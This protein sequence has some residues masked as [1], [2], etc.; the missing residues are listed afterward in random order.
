MNNINFGNVARGVMSGIDSLKE[1]AIDKMRGKEISDGQKIKE[2]SAQIKTV[3]QEIKELQKQ[4]KTGYIVEDELKTKNAELGK[5][6]GELSDLKEMHAS[7]KQILK[8]QKMKI[9]DLKQEIKELQKQ[10]KAGYVI[11]NELEEK[12]AKL[13]SELQGKVIGSKYSYFMKGD[14]IKSIEKKFETGASHVDLKTENKE[15]FHTC[16]NNS[17]RASLANKISE[18]CS[19]IK[20][21]SFLPSAQQLE[22]RYG[23]RTLSDSDIIM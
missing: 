14:Y 7:D 12:E 22:K 4:E 6:Q 23:Q 17:V 5:L 21:F 20:N 10:E 2:V 8:D 16:M 9:N 19:K 11:G 3:K 13:L 18:A 15:I 1:T